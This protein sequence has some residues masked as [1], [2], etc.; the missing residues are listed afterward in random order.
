MHHALIGVYII[1][2][3]LIIVLLLLQDWG[4][5]CRVEDANIKWYIPNEEG[6]AFVNRLLGEFLRPELQSL[7]E[8]MDGKKTL[9]R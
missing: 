9:D 6:L 2:L 3:N 5:S 1:N 8:F 7:Q 4:M